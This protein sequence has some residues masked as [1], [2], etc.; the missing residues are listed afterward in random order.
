[1]RTLYA[2]LALALPMMTT[3][4]EWDLFPLGQRSY[5]QRMS[6]MGHEEIDMYLMDSVQVVNDEEILLFNA[7]LTVGGAEDCTQ[8]IIQGL[9]WWTFDD[10][11]ISTL[12]RR[13]DTVFYFTPQSLLPFFFLPRAELG[14]SWT[15]VST[16]SANTYQEITI[17]C[18]SIEEESFWGVTDSVKTFTMAANGSSPGQVP[19]SNFT[20]RLSQNYGLLEFV[21]FDQFLV[22]PPSMNFSSTRCLGINAGGV[23]LG[24][25]LP[26]LHDYFQLSTGDLRLWRSQQF[27]VMQPTITKYYLDSVTDVAITADTIR[28]TSYRWIE[29]PGIDITGP[30]VQI[31]TY[32]NLGSSAILNCPSGWVAAGYDPIWQIDQDAGVWIKPDLSFSISSASGDTILMSSLYSEIFSVDTTSCFFMTPTDYG[33]ERRLQT[34]IGVVEL[35]Q[36]SSQQFQPDCT[37]LIGSRI[38]G[39]VNGPIALGVSERSPDAASP[40]LYPN[41]VAEVLFLH[42]D[43]QPQAP[44]C[45]ILDATGKVVLSL[46]YQGGIPVADLQQGAYVLRVYDRSGPRHARFIKQ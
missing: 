20:M 15:V 32:S 8:E 13:N 28:I 6:W 17:T 1:M 18:V 35:C 24:F 3:A 45:E 16:H 27:P 5:F 19:I 14:E 29:R 43:M 44:L 22:H 41:P 21:P 38:G 30:F 4:Q 9:P 31:E 37:T 33:M 12:Q 36:G 46:R 40:L 10:N 11:D 23:N 7:K 34:G 2:L 25:R 39:V 42:G 26:G